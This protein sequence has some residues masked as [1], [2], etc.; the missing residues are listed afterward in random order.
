MH[1][2]FIFFSEVSGK[3]VP[4]IVDPHG[5]HLGDSTEKLQG[6]AKFAEDHGTSFHRIEALTKVNGSMRVLDLTKPAV[7]EA[8]YAGGKTPLEFYESPIADDYDGPGL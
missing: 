2:D 6:L 4:S 8:I 5:H 3:V 1:P 7:R